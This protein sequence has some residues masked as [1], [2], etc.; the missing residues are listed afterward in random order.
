LCRKRTNEGF[1]F[2]AQSGDYNLDNVIFDLGS[3]V[4][5]LPRK[6][7]EL[8]GKSKLVWRLVLLRLMN[9]HKIILIIHLTRV[10]MNIDGVSSVVESKVINI[11]D[12]SKPYPTLIRL[13]WDFDNQEIINLKR[14]DMVYDVGDLKVTTPL[15]PSQGKRYIE[16]TSGNDI[17]NLYDMTMWMY[18]YVKPTAGGNPSWRSINSC[19]SNSE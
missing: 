13:E 16:T 18:D 4:N 1:I 19:E 10:P 14:R 2:S 9:Q 5:V 7:W 6:T 15:D 3:D 12:D 8:M 11:L 17:D